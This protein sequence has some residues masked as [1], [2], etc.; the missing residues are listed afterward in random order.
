[1]SSHENLYFFNKQG[2]A[3]NFRYDETTQLF[4]G[5][6]LFDENSTDTF[7]TYALYTL[8][9][10]PSFE[11]ESP[12]ELGTNKFQLFN[13]YGLHFYGCKDPLNK[14]ITKIEPVNN[15]PDFY[16]KW[17]YATNF[18]SVFPVGTLIIFN[19]SLLEF[20]NPDQTFVVVGTKKNAILIISTVDNSTFETT[21]Y[22]DY[23]NTSLYVGKTISGINAVGVYNYIDTN[24]V[25]NLSVW[26][27][28][29]FY[30]KVY[31]GKKLNVVNSNINDGIYTIKGPE[32]TDIIHFEY[33]TT[34]ALLPTNSD[35]II[36]VVLGT[37]LPKL[38]DGGLE[39]TADSKILV[40]DYIYYPT[41][42]KSG[43][44]FKVVGS[45]TN[46]NFFTTADTYDFTSNN[47]IKFYNLDDQVTF[48]GKLYQCVQA[49]TH[50]H[51][52]ET[53]RFIN[54]GNDNTHW[55]NPT[56]IRVNESTV[57]ESLLFAQIYLTKEKY[58]YDYGFTQSSSVTM[59]AAAEKYKTDL[60]IFNVD[61]YYDKGYLKADLV[62]PSRYAVVNF[63]HTQVG[64]TYSIGDEYRSFERLIEVNETLKPEFN[65]DY[66]ENF[67]YNIVFTDLDEYGL[68]I[69]IN[70]MVYEEQISYVYTGIGLDLPRT[71]DRT[72]RNWLTRNYITLYKLGINAELE[73]TYV[74]GGP[75]SSVFFNSIVIKTEYP[76][77][78]ID[79]S[80]VLVG[81]TANYFIEHSRVLFND[82]GPSLNVKINN[83]DYIIQTSNFYVLDINANLLPLNSEIIG[84][85]AGTYSTIFSTGDTANI[86]VGVDGKVSSIVLSS[87]GNIGYSIGATFSLD[88]GNSSGTSS[89]IFE[90][91][92]RDLQ[93]KAD[94][95]KTLKS[96]C[97]LYSNDLKEYGF[98]IS[99]LNSVLKFDIKQTD[100][101][102]DYTITTGKVNL[103]GL[104]DYKITK[105]IRGNH[106]SLVASNE[107][108]L[109]A[110]SSLSFEQEGFA[111]GMV[112]SLNNTYWPWMNQEFAIEFLDPLVLNLSYQGPFWDYN[113]T[114]CN[115]SPFVTIA[116]NLGFGQTECD[117]ISATEG[118]QF[119]QYQ[120][121]NTQ[122]NINFYPNT[123]TLSEYESTT[124]L[125]DIKYIQLSETVLSLG[126][127]LVVH[128][129]YSGIYITTITLSG[130]VNSIKMEFNPIN[131]YVYCLS[132]NKVWIVD[133]STN[134]LI[135]SFGLT[136]DAVDLL[137]NPN[138]GDVYISY[139]NLS[140]VHIFKST[141]FNSTPDFP[142]STFASTG[143]MAYN[144]FENDIYV[145]T[146]DNILRID[147]NTR[148]LQVVYNLPG[149]ID[150]I[151]YEPVNE[152]IFVYDSTDLYRIDNGSL[153][154]LSIPT[155]TFNDIIFN[156]LTGD[157]NISDSSFEVTRLGL[158]GSILKQT[159]IAN[160]GYMALNQYDGAI[161]I[162]SQNANSVVVI[163][164][165]TQQLVYQN[166]LS[167]PTTKIIYNPDRKSIWVLQPS[168]NQ[169]IEIEVGLNNDATVVVGT[170][171]Y[172]ND[173]VYGTLDPNFE[174]RDDIW[175]KTRD[176]FRRPRENFT[177]DYRV[178]YY[179]KWFSDNVPQFFLYD[180]SG[181][182]LVRTT[183]GSYSYIGPKP[184]NNIVLNRNSNTDVSKVSVSEYQQTIFDKIEYSLSYIDD[185]VD[186]S[187]S[188][189]PLQLFVGFQ[190]QNE[191]ALRSILQLYKKEDINFTIDTK[192]DTEVILQTLDV[193]GPDKR[194]LISLSSYSTEY[195]TDK[196]LKPGQHIVI[197]LKDKTSR[198]NQYISYN[199]GTLLKIREVYSKSLI[200]DFF[201][202]TTDILDLEST[203]VNHPTVNDVLYLS[204]GIKVIDKEIGRF[205]TYGQTE[206]ED[207]RHKIELGNVGKLISP[208]DVFIFK[209]YDIEEGGID[210]VYLNMKRKEMLM[211][212]HLIYPYIGSYKS[213][214]NAINFFGYNDLQ[215]N[216]YY[217]NIDASSENFLKLF[218]VEIPD[219]FDNSVE[220]WTENDFIRHTMPNDNFEGTNLFNLTYFIT[221]K[222]GNNTLNYT[223]DEVIIKLQGLKYWLKKN[224]IPLTHKI[225]DITGNV[226][227]TGGTQIQH[228]LQDTRIVNIYDN[229]TPITSKL[230]EAYLM[231]VNSGSTV[232]NCVLDLYSI[233]P[234]VGADKTK[235]GLVVPPKPFNGKALNLPDYFTIKIR[236]YK[237]YKEW[238]P[239]SS[240]GFG[241]RVSYYGKLYESV[242]QRVEFN[243]VTGVYE[244]VNSANK[245][246]SPRK[247]ENV[248]PWISSQSYSET[249]LVEYN[250]DVYVLL[251]STQSNTTPYSDFTNNLSSSTYI[252]N[253]V[254]EWKEIDWNPVQT[255]SEFRQGNDLLPFNFTLDSNIDTYLTVEVVSDNGYGCIYNDKKNYE[256]RGNKDLIENNQIKDT[257]GPFVPFV[258]INQ[259]LVTRTFVPPNQIQIEPPPSIYPPGGSGNNIGGIGWGL[260]QNLANQP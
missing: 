149:V 68:K 12:G 163:D 210:W 104:N 63:Y 222:E 205:F 105:K 221:D 106:G 243:I 120:F 185:E 9:R 246:N 184:L 173:N 178:Q 111:T 25:N 88:F 166:S 126:D 139:S 180:F 245:L 217:R 43:Q 123:Y 256:I 199:N 174:E 132:L 24:Y 138:N 227:F 207:I 97:D 150:Y 114:I 91:D 107:V 67:K 249:S 216:E 124:N 232:Y 90:V 92:D 171:S 148:S 113:N 52:D 201:N 228:K 115:K 102:F 218:K 50:S 31:R 192:E 203:T 223:L 191:G 255:I 140:E 230:N 260:L 198:T 236:T 26:N 238:V 136:N 46:E 130:N 135:T 193:N 42:L 167:A 258:P 241:D 109:S 165:I 159:N 153:S 83:K 244:L 72:L 118:G 75:I 122:F 137:V 38:Y 213:I 254:T 58:Y 152:S 168:F 252:W 21:Y 71:I 189:E 30:D 200:V 73:Y 157:M 219:I 64:P 1:M 62:Y 144:E 197:Y 59:A 22:S 100:V 240:Y 36:E 253:K 19:Q 86:S 96:W 204:F 177:D 74:A 14:Q 108:I 169:I 54:P 257:T 112:F 141:T 155:Q 247:Y 81:T 39:I 128:D 84:A 117:P 89:I 248:T 80:S 188:V 226:Y 87:V 23:S 76:N 235:T 239:F 34:P 231:P 147:G 164:S 259:I 209:Q 41:M 151:L 224:I 85:T 79:V 214:I 194:G 51:A 119:N 5:D 233:I 215:L 95:P 161:Y 33:L 7:K 15:D 61:L 56:F 70:K 121:S 190:S 99:N 3:L 181:D 53:T 179:W 212:K 145:I 11:F 202:L 6:I 237:T 129:S 131:N 134:Y 160:Y 55:S 229:M 18:E 65:Y 234:D 101:A 162:S 13:E 28:P 45:V 250:R 77:V 176:Y 20:T 10:I 66:S 156:N 2:D 60:D 183:T 78:P 127:D 196:G 47:N 27:E 143:K 48:D 98:I 110:S 49:Y 187:T 206:E 44:E 186:I 94:I 172:I 16:S 251:S 158:D 225:L 8:E 40:T 195:F 35:L 103:P 69:I 175:L 37:D 220:G 170:A 57:E 29:N 82:L 146:V 208:E 17:I 142:I 116:F 242:Y 182:Q 93:R 4:Q 211:M 32:I 125:V 154:T 133:P